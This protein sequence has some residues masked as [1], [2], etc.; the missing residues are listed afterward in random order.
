MVKNKDSR[1]LIYRKIDLHVHTPESECFPDK[2]ITPIDIVNQAIKEGL[3][4]IAIT[5]HNS[6]VWIDSIKKVAKNKLV[7]F[8][9]V[10]ITTT[11]GKI[12]IHIIAIF[13]TGKSTKDIENLLGELKILPEKYGKPDAYTT[14]SPS[15]VIDIISSR[16]ALAIAP[17]ANSSQ[18]I[19]GG[20]KGE[21]RTG[22]LN[23][24][25]LSAIEATNSDFKS[26]AKKQKRTRVIDL[27]DGTHEEYPKLAVYQSS[28]NLNE[29]NGTHEISKIGS[30]YSYFKLDE[31]DL[32][33]LRQCYCDPD[34]RIK[35]HDDFE[36]FSLPK[37]KQMEISQGFL[38]KQKIFFHQGL[39]S[40]VGGKGTG[41]SLIVEFLRFGLTQTSD[42]K[43]VMA[44]HKKKLDKRLELL[45]EINVDFELPTGANYRITRILDGASNHVECMNTETGE[46]YQGEIAS[47]F[48]ILAYSQNEV[49]KIAEDE[50]AQLRLTDSFIDTSSYKEQ[51]RILSSKLDKN[52]KE[53]SASIKASYDVESYTTQI[54]TISEQL[55]NIDKALK[56][57]LFDEMRLLEQKQT[58][59]NQYVQF[60]NEAQAEL[61]NTLNNI[62]SNL[63]APTIPKELTTDPDLKL[64]QKLAKATLRELSRT[65]KE[66]TRFVSDNEKALEVI[67]KGWKPIFDRKSKQY[68]DMLKKA[69]GDKKKLEAE[70]RK[71]QSQ[72]D[73]FKAELNKHEKIKSKLKPI[74]TSRTSLLNEFDK[75]H[76]DY[77]DSRK[78]LFDKLTSQSLG[79]LKLDIQYAGNRASYKAK[80]WDL[81]ARSRIH[82]TDTDTV[83]DNL[84]PREF[85][86]LVIDK[87]IETIHQKTNLAT[88][89][90]ERLVELLNSAEDLSEVLS[91]SYS[92]HP[93][94]I[95][96]IQFRKD[97]K[98]YYPISEISTG[99]KCTSLLIIAL[100]EGTRP[101]IIDQPEDS[102]D[103]TSVYEDIVM[104]LRDGKEKRQF[105]LTTHN[106]SVGVA[107]DSDNFIVL[108]STSSRGKI[109]C[110][111]AID[112]KAVKTEVIQHL[113][114]GPK[115]YGLRHKKYHI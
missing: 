74:R 109:D 103:T 97:D 33:G 18:G 89:N 36:I 24:V 56:N 99:Q 80:L 57:K 21:P 93:Q 87:K 81:R 22:V 67:Y 52:D 23:N 86:D 42:D 1:G 12:N 69:G 111:G 40:I 59:F 31:I 63:I 95:P 8:P 55:K 96:S 76:K 11:A 16:G 85:M 2:S 90:I 15:S 7:V 65:I 50:A 100:S 92:V 3:D 43:D 37:L 104:K 61:G 88:A 34:V 113:E 107:S 27:L 4:A 101:I 41:K 25:N 35:Q 19:M 105:I 64:S 114:G 70:R 94:D 5:D 68:D 83:A 62:Q 20:M 77:Y 72:L 108:K 115:P 51:L 82:K 26:V 6:G 75:V 49:I 17:H 73:R 39:N 71:L 9:G 78:Q 54:S 53:L 45:G 10:E 14:F 32:E 98:E 48:P 110:Y 58:I 13:N 91:L 112:R 102:L 38:A 47:L 106:A 44:D 84:M 29:Q 46:I 30:R 60:N 66:V 28:D 79:K